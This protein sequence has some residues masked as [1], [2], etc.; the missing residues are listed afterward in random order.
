METLA[1]IL[2]DYRR[3]VGQLAASRSTTEAT[4][5][6]AIQA[7][8]A[9][10]LRE[11]RLPFEVRTNISQQRSGGG[12][13]LPDLAFVDG[14]SDA[15]A[16]LGEIKSPREELEELARSTE[17]RD[18]V[19]RY[20]AQT[21]VVLLS[22]VRAFGLLTT[23]P[24]FRAAGPVP[25]AHRR[26]LEVVE[27]WPSYSALAQG[28]PVLE[29]AGAGLLE[30]LDT[31]VTE[32]APIAQPESL[33]RIL[34]RLARRAKW[35]L[36]AHF[37]QAV[38]PLLDDFAKA[39][40]IHFEGDEG[41][42]FLRSS[43]IQTAFYGLFAAWALWRHAGARRPFRWEDLGE[44]LKIPFLGGL[45]HEFRHPLR[46]REL[47]LA[48]HLD[49]ATDALSRVD[50]DRFFARFTVAPIRGAGGSWSAA[51]ASAILYFYEPF[52]E[53]FDPV[54][55][56][57]LGVWYTPQEIVRYQVRKTDRLLREELGC[58]RGFADDRV[59]VL[60]PCCGTGAYLI[61]VLRT[62]AEQLEAEGSGALLGPKLLDALCRRVVGFELLTAPFVIA[63]L[64]VYLILADLGAEPDAS[65]RPAIFL[66]NSLT[67]WEG[68]EQLKLQFPE[69]QEEHDAAR[70]IKHEARIIAILGNPPYDRFAGVP[71]EEEADLVDP[72][73]GIRRDARG[74]QVG[75]SELYERWGVRKHLLDDLYIRFFR[76][77]ELRIG[78]KAEC[79]V[80][81]WISNYS[82]LTGR[83][84]PL[85]RESLL[86]NFDA[87]WIDSL[88]GDKYRTGKVVPK[89]LP[90]EGT[91]D[92]SVFTTEQD[93]RGIQVGTAVT[94]LL[95]RRRRGQEK[96]PAAV[97]YRDFWG[98]S[99][100][101]RQAL[102][103]ALDLDG[104][105]GRA[106]RRLSARP[107]GPR[108]Y[109]V[110]TPSAGNRWRLVPAAVTG[111][112]EDWP[113]LDELFPVGF[114]GVNPNR[115]LE[116]SVIDVDPEVLGARM[117]DYFS[118]LSFEEVRRRH[119]VLCEPRARYQPHQVRERLRKTSE[120]R[121][122]R[123][124][125]YLVFPLD[126]RFIYYEPETKLLNERRPEL[127]ANLADNFFLVAVPQPR[128]VSESRPLVAT[129]LF[130]LHLH[131]RGSV[132]FPAQV[133][134][135]SLPRSLFTPEEPAAT[136]PVA[137]LTPDVWS[138]FQGAWRL[139]GGRDGEEARRLVR[140][141]FHLTLALAHAPQFEDDH[142]SALAQDWL[143]LPIP[144]D[145]TVFT[146]I[147][148]LGETVAR[149]LDPLADAERPLEELLGP[150]RRTLA[151]V[152]GKG[153]AVVRERDLAVTVSYN[154]AAQGGWVARARSEG[155]VVASAW[156]ESTG[157]LWL[158]DT[159]HLR[160]VP[161]RVWRYELGGYPVV[162]K[163]LGYRDARRR[164]G[165]GLTLA[166]VDHLRGIVHRVAALLLLHERL[167]A[168][169][170]QAVARPFTGAELGVPG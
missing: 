34:A 161:E 104:S 6:P 27:V 73:K 4:F 138:S 47:G 92:Q 106:R 118:E 114:Q 36:P 66:T 144:R 86:H 142:R 65:H 5:Y 43:L 113:A 95:K 35:A 170:G 59:V 28:G 42:E 69:L 127:W 68:P 98:L 76:L 151:V 7:L 130:D 147:A 33:A 164:S 165:R 123:I 37:S 75:T 129:S 64:Q 3:E 13:D 25:P 150:A 167:D 53:A 133:R 135:A 152:A 18:Q 93:P 126:R 30:L 67:G 136:R 94:T 99:R 78:E 77:A 121:S 156:G 23:D 62:I 108:E 45:F 100:A 96:S 56:K 112:Y 149:L 39:L 163:W 91:S 32:F 141:L 124:V 137:N 80:V 145:R 117:R 154:G 44:Y 26:L 24:A 40:G 71:V 61:E 97:Y 101:K 14:A 12:A 29:G 110:V 22:N 134:P 120:F 52:L 155:E 9:G 16:V 1:G 90:A 146:E 105:D 148:G 143:H 89:G 72:Y 54:L 139:R 111:G 140:R 157:D 51:A 119:P 15:V 55:R 168:A 48:E 125:P 84:H 109:E 88:N 116:G 21:G 2:A 153:T 63:Q 159:V 58:E 31:A 41:E 102:V 82:Y 160:N 158:N 81:S 57:K 17:R 70:R 132:G 122:D 19:G 131:D 46:L 103:A 85:M 38:R 115:G 162:K 8:L 10:V 79:G 166:E 50:A 107:E 60:D 87:L 169:Y 49:R 11:A 128:Q 74:R 20:L 83:S